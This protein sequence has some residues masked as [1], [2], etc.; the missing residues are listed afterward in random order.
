MHKLMHSR[1]DYKKGLNV[2]TADPAR[3]W[4]IG[5]NESS[6]MYGE[7]KLMASKDFEISSDCTIE[8]ELSVT[9]THCLFC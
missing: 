9:N 2:L 8:M 7:Q 5:A 1:I 6:S 3:L 4:L